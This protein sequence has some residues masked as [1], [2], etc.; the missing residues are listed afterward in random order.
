MEKTR[1][2]VRVIFFF[3][4]LLLIP[5]LS[6]PQEFPTKPINILVGFAPGG[7]VDVATRVIASKAEKF[8]GQPFIISNN[9]GG[10]GSVSCAIA[11]KQPAD[12]YHLVSPAS[13]PLIRTPQIRKVSYKLEDFIPIMYFGAPQTVIVVRADSPWKTLKEF[14]EFAKNNPGKVTYATMGTG[15]GPHFAMEAVAKKEQIKWTHVPYTAGL[16]HVPLLGGHV[17]AAASSSTVFPL[18]RAGKLRLLATA[19]EKRP[20][21]FPEV[22]TLWELGYGYIND[23][24]CAIYA[25]KGTPLSIVKKLDDAFKRAMDDPEFIQ[26]LDNLGYD[27]SYCNHEDTK[28]F[29]EGAYANVGKT[30]KELGI[31][32]E[33]EKQ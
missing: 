31:S 22:P 3:G 2:M 23:G 7:A 13:S 11:A 1:R 29:L 9:G 19:N 10:G 8:L 26:A 4:F 12:G 21:S 24:V 28:K 33:F 16:P 32:T 6:F 30:I 14:A 18:V 20:K 5:T 25:P 27:I 17:M 15:H